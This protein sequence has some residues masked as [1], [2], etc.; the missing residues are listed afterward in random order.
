MRHI[1]RGIRNLEKISQ[2]HL[3][4]YRNPKNIE[5][6]GKTQ[7]Q[8]GQVY[9][10]ICPCRKKGAKKEKKGGKKT[11]VKTNTNFTLILIL[12]IYLDTVLEANDRETS[13]N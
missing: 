4:F 11:I 2:T 13:C 3:S 9:N 5:N 7:L 1:G 12:T 8:I 6:E 10:A